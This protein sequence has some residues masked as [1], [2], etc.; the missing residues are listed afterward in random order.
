MAKKS[1]Q[2]ESSTSQPR[3]PGRFSYDGLDRVMH[4]KAR[5]G[6]MTCLAG[7][8]EG[9]TFGELKELCGLTDGN[10]SRHLKYLTDARL[11]RLVRDESRNK[12]SAR[13]QTT[14]FLTDKGRES[15]VQYLAELQR[16][17]GDAQKQMGATPAA[18][19]GPTAKA[20]TKSN[21]P[22]VQ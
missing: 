20:Q 17:I 2:P 16:V 12:L 19:R 6:L 21:R 5:L 14:C 4:E 10:L 18:A 8:R 11:V 15:F 9:L 3:S 7:A 22:A 13:P 1:T